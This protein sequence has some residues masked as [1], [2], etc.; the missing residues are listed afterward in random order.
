VSVALVCVLVLHV[1]TLATELDRAT[2]E[3]VGLSSQRLLRLDAVM[4]AEIDAG[5]KSGIAVLIARRGKIAF[6]KAFGYAELEG[7]TPLRTDSY[8][9]V[10]SMTKPIV[11]AALLTLYEEGRFQLTDPL[12]K[13]I[14]AMKD[15]K[16]YAGDDEAGEMVLE[17]PKRKI[18]I[19]DVFRHTAGLSSHAPPGEEPGNRVVQA[20]Q[21]AEADYGKI[22]SLR[23]LA[24][25]TL[26]PLPLLY[27]P[28]EKWVYSFAHD[29]QA[30]LV[31][32]FSG[33]PID[34]FLH[35]RIF[36]PLDMRDSFYGEPV[37]GGPRCTTV[38]GPDDH[39]GLKAIDRPLYLPY[40]RFKEHPMGGAGLSMTMMDYAKFAQMLINGGELNG[41]R[42]LGRKTVELMTA[43]HLPPGMSM[44]FEGCGYGLGVGVCLS[45]A[46]SGNLGSAGQF[47][48]GG[49]A[50][51]WVIMD[52]K[53]E[54]VALMFTQYVPADMEFTRRFKTLVYQTIVD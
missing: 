52:P 14:P 3:S 31:E 6:Q 35:E 30:Y 7:K 23:E 38:Y 21:E 5:R 34:R 17:A 22:G 33:M 39:G 12:E 50:T 44:F 29:V 27:H 24:E 47:F 53:E 2:P 11:S 8:F 18:T 1:S 25:E 40:S 10:Y 36:K 19:Q 54:L 48:W 41:E 45:P 28:G 46:E 37:S 51:T 49:Y 42:I 20:Y 32:Y 26:P 43:N 9:R 16:V 13:Y 15:V 4:Q